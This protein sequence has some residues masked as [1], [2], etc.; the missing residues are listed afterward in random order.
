MCLAGAWHA[1]DQYGHCLFLDAKSRESTYKCFW[2]IA[3]AATLIEQ[4]VTVNPEYHE[5][6]LSK[7]V[8]A[9]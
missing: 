8:L 1:G 2:E 9:R 3:Q 4:K 6:T 5:T 7:N